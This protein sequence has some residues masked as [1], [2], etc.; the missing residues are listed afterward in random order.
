MRLRES[1]ESRKLGAGSGEVR[2]RLGR[3]TGEA[4]RGESFGERLVGERGLTHLLPTENNDCT[5][6]LLCPNTLHPNPT[7]NSLDLTP[8]TQL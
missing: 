2:E 5:P 1:R 3:G 6:K 4:G 7:C 8:S